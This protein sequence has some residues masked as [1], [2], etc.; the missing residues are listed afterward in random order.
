LWPDP[1]VPGPIEVRVIFEPPV[2]VEEPDPTWRERL[3]AWGAGLLGELRPWQT[4]AALA[5]AMLPIPGVGYSAATTWAYAMGE[6]RE[7]AGVATG[8]VVA[9][10]LLVLAIS[11][12]RSAP[13][14]PR[15]LLL[16]V[17]AFGVWGSLS[18]YDVI[19]GLTGVGR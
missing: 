10:G 4:V 9:G 13:S 17:S 2:L 6:L 3:A 19:Q 8:Y 11:R 7:Q 14:A 5:G 12:F 18:W 15:L 1:P 16:V